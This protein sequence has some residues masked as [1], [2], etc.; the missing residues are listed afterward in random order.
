MRCVKILG[1]GSLKIL[2]DITD[3][4]ITERRNL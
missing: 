2:K 4:I 1:V 3:K